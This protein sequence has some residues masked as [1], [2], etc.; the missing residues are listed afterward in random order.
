MT[1]INELDSKRKPLTRE[2]ISQGFRDNEDAINAESYWAGV[3]YA[4]KMHG[5][6]NENEISIT[7]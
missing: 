4:E 2:E 7:K 5:V 3:E 6:H 1:K